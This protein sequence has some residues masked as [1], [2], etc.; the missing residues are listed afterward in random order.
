VLAFSMS[1]P[2]SRAAIPT[3][4]PVTVGVGRAVIAAVLGAIALAIARSPLPRGRRLPRLGVVALG[5][6]VGFP[7]C[8]SL[9]LRDTTAAHGA[10]LVGL[11]PIAT[12]LVGALR[13]AERPPRAFWIS[14]L[15]GVAAVLVFA[16]TQGAGR[17]QSADGWLAAAV[18]LG[19]IGYA[20]GGALA[21]ELGGW[22][23]ISWALVL[24]LPLT[25]PV[26]VVGLVTGPPVSPTPAAWLG[27]GYVCGVSMFAGFVAWY[28]G[29]AEG[30]IAQISQL[31]LAQPVLTLGWAALLLS[32]SISA[33][34][35]VAALAI[36]AAVAG[37]Q[38]SRR[39]SIPH[40]RVAAP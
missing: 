32:E 11:L 33:A 4:G 25:L 5:V 9:A 23:V 37:T 14:C 34:T 2:A 22:Q 15:L 6:V 3:F 26:T 28:R 24:S 12:A 21:R 35:T 7:L 10:I 17:I 16:A 39:S 36:V 20:E 31:Q 18:A 29:L 8:S 13:G 1:F 27:L 40:R 30:G 38:R 19:A